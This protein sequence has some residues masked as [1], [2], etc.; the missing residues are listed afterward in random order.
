MKLLMIIFYEIWHGICNY[1][2]ILKMKGEKKM[3]WM[4]DR[5]DKVGMMTEKELQSSEVGEDE[6]ILSEEETEEE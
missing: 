2:L 4:C 5:L 6:G 3:G 1:K